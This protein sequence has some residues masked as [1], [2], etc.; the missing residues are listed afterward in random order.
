MAFA[1][2]V[3]QIQRT[4]AFNHAQTQILAS[5]RD[6]LLPHLISRQFRLSEAEVMVKEVTV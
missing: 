3:E 5:I 1:E 2:I 6:T 4:I